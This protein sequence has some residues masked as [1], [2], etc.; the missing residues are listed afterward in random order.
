MFSWLSLCHPPQHLNTSHALSAFLNE[1]VEEDA[2]KHDWDWGDDKHSFPECF[3]EKKTQ[4]FKPIVPRNDLSR[5]VYMQRMT[6]VQYY[7][8]RYQGDV[9]LLS[10][11]IDKVD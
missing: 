4:F 5:S 9:E 2:D 10:G 11:K 1:G 6:C 3:L 8:T 7:A